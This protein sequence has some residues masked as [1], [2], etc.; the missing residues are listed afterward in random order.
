MLVPCHPASRV[1]RGRRG[2]APGRDATGRDSLVGWLGAST[3][4]RW[5]ARRTRSTPTSWSGTLLA[6][7]HGGD[8]PTPPRPTWW[9]STPA[10][11]SRRPGRSR[12]TPSWPSSGGA[13]PGAELVVTGCLAERYG[14]EL[15]AALPEV[16]RV[17]G[18]GVPGAR[19]GRR[20]RRP[21][22]RG[23]AVVPSLDL[24]NL[25]RPRSARAVG[26]REDR[27]GLRP[28]LRVLRHPELPRAAAVAARPSRSWPRSTS[29][30]PRRSCSSPRT[31][32]S[33]GKDVEGLGAG[34]IVPL[35]R[36][37]AEPGA[38]TRLLYLY[39][40]DLT[41]GLIDAICATGRALL[42]PVAPARV[43]AAAAPHAPVGRRRALPAP[44]RRHPAPLRPTP[45][46][47]RT[48]SSATRARPRPTTTSCSTSSTRPSSTGAGSSPSAGRTA[49]TPPTSTARCADELMAERARRAARAAGRH[50]RGAARRADRHRRRGARRRARRRPQRTARRPRSTAS[51]TCPTHLAVGAFAPV[52]VVGAA[53]PRPRGGRGR[54]GGGVSTTEAP[55]DPTRRR[56]VGQRRH[57]G[58]HAAGA[59]CC[60]C[61]STAPRA[62][63]RRCAMWTALCSTD[64]IDGWLARRHGTTRSG[65]FLDPL[66]D[67]VLVLGAMF[68]L[69]ARGRVL[70][71]A[72][73]R[74]RRPG[75]ADQPVPL[76][77]GRA[78]RVRSRPARG[79][80]SRR[81]PSSSPWRFALLPARPRRDAT[82][83][84]ARRCCGSPSCSPC[85][86]GSQYL[87][88]ARRVGGYRR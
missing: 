88:N 34:A 51:S 75:A 58:A 20:S 26:V 64:G 36:A 66:A 27:R 3:S 79:Q 54:A 24:L 35:V 43:E 81:S 41:D 44:H 6:D 80:G 7:G 19:S 16:D 5:A 30:T 52:R 60:S 78:G 67:K 69:V 45:R 73:G 17:A 31:W 28:R 86:P 29:S 57:R 1:R 46:S 85:G 55:H 12:S 38:R 23:A 84:V 63:G 61:S 77:G 53:R 50:H 18:F 9:W 70:G 71:R 40:S 83:T 33:Y 37:V 8:R 4:R 76:G 21:A 2:R 62:R 15:A 47:A 13:G 11:S 10:P 68:T 74:H 25:P 42:R 49:P 65:A 22:R 48:S 82:W 87:M 14:D 56:H 72:G 39:P 32:P 59:R